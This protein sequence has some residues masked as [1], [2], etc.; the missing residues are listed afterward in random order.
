MN[1]CHKTAEAGSEQLPHALSTAINN[2]DTNL[3]WWEQP[4]LPS[5]Q[6]GSQWVACPESVQV[7]LPL[8]AEQRAV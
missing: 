7:P 5:L 2:F 8:L 4:L 1:V 3:E 6:D